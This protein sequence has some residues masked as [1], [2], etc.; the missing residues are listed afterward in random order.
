MRKDLLDS[1]TV[2]GNQPYD[3]PMCKNR[4]CV[5]VLSDRKWDRVRVRIV[6]CEACSEY[7]EVY[8]GR[9]P[10]PDYGGWACARVA[11]PYR[12]YPFRRSV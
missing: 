9:R 8:Y 6:G 11:G 5:R 2:V 7:L 10:E 12:D 4:R 1:A 3:C